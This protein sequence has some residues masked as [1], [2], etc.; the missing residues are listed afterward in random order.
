VIFPPLQGEGRREAA[1]WGRAGECMSE[2]LHRVQMLVLTGDYLV[3]DHGFDEL[4]EDAIVAR[5]AIAGVA[6]AITVEDYPDRFRGPSVLALQH[7]AEGRA[8]HVVWAIPA[9]E[10]R[11]AVLV[12]AYRPNPRLWDSEFR[13]R[14]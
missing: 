3:S 7:D 2:T 9:G 11:P 13:K 12:T 14:I 5:D 10:R 6:D 4:E 8:I 1:G